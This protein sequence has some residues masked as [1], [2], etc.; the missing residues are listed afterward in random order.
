MSNIERLNEAREI[1]GITEE[2]LKRGDEFVD[3]LLA[4]RKSFDGLAI[5]HEEALTYH[6]APDAKQYMVVIPRLPIERK[7]T[8]ISYDRGPEVHE[9]N[10]TAEPTIIT[11]LEIKGLVSHGEDKDLQIVGTS[12]AWMTGNGYV[13]NT[14]REEYSFNPL[15]HQIAI[16]D[17]T[18]QL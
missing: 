2:A 18:N 5:S 4:L 17:E 16:V 14:W 3:A 8:R 12:P 6:F 13:A 10:T 1:P 11:A 7:V 15:E 9:T